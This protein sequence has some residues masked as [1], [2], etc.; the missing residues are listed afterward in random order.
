MVMVVQRTVA[1]RKGETLFRIV[2]ATQ[3]AAWHR[4]SLARFC[5]GEVSY[6]MQRYSY[7]KRGCVEYRKATARQD[8]VAFGIGIVL[9]SKAGQQLRAMALSSAAAQQGSVR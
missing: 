7:V 4:H 3:R 9:L 2:I 6:A 8:Y 1:Q 5:V